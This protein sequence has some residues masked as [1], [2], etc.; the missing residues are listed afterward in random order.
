ML[1][2]ILADGFE[3]TFDDQDFDDE[4]LCDIEITLQG[5]IDIND[6]EDIRKELKRIS[7]WNIC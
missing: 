1:K 6:I 3:L 4:N 5:K 2:T 7:E